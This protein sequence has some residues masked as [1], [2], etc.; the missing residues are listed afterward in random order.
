[1]AGADTVLLIVK[2]LTE[3]ELLRL[4]K[5]TRSL[6]MEPLVE[7]NTVSELKTALK[8]DSKVIGVNNR[9]LTT[10]NVDLGTT[11]NVIS[12]LQDENNDIVVLAL[13]GISTVEDINSFTKDGVYGF[14]IGESLMRK[15]DKV[16]E[17]IAELKSA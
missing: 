1:L 6:G 8:V 2:M 12:G 11:S 7:V 17:F 14:L 16:G 4:V 9:D 13:S 10:F 3:S 5:Y 15:G